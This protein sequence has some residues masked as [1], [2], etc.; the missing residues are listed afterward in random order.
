MIIFTDNK[1]LN[2]KQ[3]NE[4]LTANFTKHKI[5]SIKSCIKISN[6]FLKSH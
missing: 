6:I 4:N 1:N 5:F 2:E 3:L